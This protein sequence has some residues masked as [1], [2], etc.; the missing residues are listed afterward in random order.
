MVINK[1][2]NGYP[3]LAEFMGPQFDQ[4]VGFFRQFAEANARNLL[5]MQAEILCLERELAAEAHMDENG[6]DSVRQKFARNVFEMRRSGDSR[7]WAKILEIRE[8]LDAYST[9][10]HS[11]SVVYP[12]GYT[13]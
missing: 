5:Y 10:N 2:R 3:G 11:P 9:S 8:K 7:Q 1:V 6:P 12:H 4:G 13:R